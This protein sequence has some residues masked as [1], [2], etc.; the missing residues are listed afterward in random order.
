MK[1][2]HKFLD[3]TADVFFVAKADTL[4][5]LFNECAL[6]VEETMV[7]VAK[8]KIVD[9]IKILG[10]S[11]TVESLLFDFLDELLFFK[12]Y[13]Q[14]VFSKFEIEIQEKEEKF[15]LVCSAQGEKIDFSRHDPKVDVKAITMHEF[16]VEKVKDGWKAQVLIDI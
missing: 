4:P 6:A 1:P 13:R 16:K 2:L 3:H 10:E 7:D 8:V 14:L 5:A 15:S 11:A 12:D 9:I